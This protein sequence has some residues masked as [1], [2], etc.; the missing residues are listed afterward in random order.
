MSSLPGKHAKVQFIERIPNKKTAITTEIGARKESQKKKHGLRETA[1]LN[2]TTTRT[3]VL[4]LFCRLVDEKSSYA[5][6][7][8]MFIT[9]QD[10]IVELRNTTTKQQGINELRDKVVTQQFCDD[11]LL[12]LQS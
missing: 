9:M 2:N 7:K 11:C 10:E 3:R 8:K 5:E 12:Q 1:L 6:I 4:L